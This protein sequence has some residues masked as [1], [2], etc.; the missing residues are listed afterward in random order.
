MSIRPAEMMDCINRFNQ[1]VK[2]LTLDM[3]KRF[4]DDALVYRAKERIMVAAEMDPVFIIENVGRYLYKFR[5]QILKRNGDFFIESEYDADFKAA[6]DKSQVE[7]S[8]YII[9]KAKEAYIKLS[10]KEKEDYIDM[11]VGMLKDYIRYLAGRKLG[12]K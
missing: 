1:R 3:Y 5:E 11:V 9:P 12:L 6:A 8:V 7:L 4:P 10:K 2:L